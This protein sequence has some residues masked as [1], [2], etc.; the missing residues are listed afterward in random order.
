[1][2]KVKAILWT[3]YRFND[4]YTKVVKG[5]LYK[6]EKEVE[7][8]KHGKIIMVREEKEYWR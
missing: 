3:E 6:Y 2:K 8:K 1:M 4:G 5:K 7:I